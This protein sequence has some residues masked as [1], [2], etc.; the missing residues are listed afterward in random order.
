MEQTFKGLLFARAI[1]VAH[2]QV[3]NHPYHNLVT[4]FRCEEI[5]YWLLFAI[6]QQINSIA[7]AVWLRCK[8]HTQIPNPPYHHDLLTDVCPPCGH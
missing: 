8:L 3:P 5:D 6:L 2:A 4:N 1:K 7:A